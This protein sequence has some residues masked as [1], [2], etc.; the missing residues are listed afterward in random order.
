MK[1]YIEK[2]KLSLSYRQDETDLRK[3]QFELRSILSRKLIDDKE[4]FNQK[5]YTELTSKQLVGEFTNYKIT[6]K[7]IKNYNDF[8]ELFLNDYITFYLENLYNN[9][10]KDFVINDVSHK[11]ILLLLDLKFKKL[12]DEEE[13]LG[14][15]SK[16]SKDEEKDKITLQNVISKILWLEANS[17]YIKNILDL[18]NIIS[19]NI[20]YDENEKDFLFKQMLN[21]LS[22]I[23]IKYEP[24]GEPHLILVNIPFYK[25]II[26]IFKCIVDEQ[27]IKNVVS[28]NQN[29]N[30]YSY[31]KHLEY[32]FK[33]LE[34]LDQ[35]LRLNIIEL[36]VLK[37]FI[38]IYNVFELS[39]KIKKLDISLLINYLTKSLEI[40][41]KND[42][43]KINLLCD[44]LKKLI[45]IIKES[46]YDLSKKE[47][48][49]GDTIYYE[50]ISGVFLN[51]L[52][53]ENNLEYKIYILNEFLLDD[54]K[55]FIQ[56]NQILKIILE[57]FVSTDIY[58][59]QKSLFNLSD[60]KLKIL[61]ENTNNEWIKE[62]LIYTFE[63]ISLIYILNLIN[64]DENIN[65]ENNK[66]E[67]CVYYLK[68]FFERCIELLENLY[69]D[70]LKKEDDKE[71]NI[72]LQKFF[73]LAFIRVYLRIFIDWVNNNKLKNSET[74]EIIKIINGD[75]NN[76]F[77][78][79]VRYFIYKILYNMYAQDISK[80]FDD[81]IIEKFHLNSYN[82]FDLLKKERDKL[83]SFK[84][85]LFIEAYKIADEEYKIYDEQFNKLSYCLNNSGDKESELME[86][87]NNN[88]VDIFYSV[89]S[90][91]ISAYLSSSPDDDKK[92][93]LSNIIQ[94]AFDEKKQLLNIFKL[95]I[96][97][98][99]Y[100]KTNISLKSAEILQFSLRYCLNSDEISEDCDN[101]YY[102]LYCNDQNISSFIPGN[103]L[104]ESKIY[105]AYSKIKKYLYTH[106]SSHGVYICTCNI[107]KENEEIT[108]K[109]EEGN[110]GYPKESEKCQYCGEPIGKD[111]EQK[112]FYERNYYFRIF[113]DEKDLEEESKD[114]VKGNCMTLETFFNKFITPKL[115]EDSK[116]VNISRK[117]YFELNDKPI[118]NQ[119]Q[120]CFRLMNLILYSHLFTNVLSNGKD[121]LFAG[122]NLSYLDYIVGNW[123]K[124]KLLL[125]EKGINNMYIFINI[126]YKDLYTFLNE[127]KQINDY[128]KLL[129]VEKQIEKI[130][131]NKIFKKTQKIKQ[132]EYSKYEVY[133]IFYQKNKNK[134]K[135]KDSN[136]KTSIIK[137]ING[138]EFYK[139]EKEYPYYKNF[140]YSDSLNLNF[141]KQKLEERDKEKYPVIDLYLNKENLEK[142]I[143]KEFLDFNF[144]IKSLLNE[145]S[146]QIKK[147]DI[148]KL[149]FEK[150]NVYKIYKKRCETFV[151]II[152][153]KNKEKQL[154]EKSSLDNY[155]INGS[156]EKGKKLIEIYKEYAEIQNNL[157]ENIIKRINA[158][159]FDVLECQEINIQEAQNED[160]LTL[161][162]ENKSESNEIFLMNT[163]R[164]IYGNNSKVKYNNYN[165]YSIIFDKIEK[166]FEDTL[167]RNASFL[168]TDEILEM[169]YSAEDFL[170]DGI[171]ELNKNIKSESLNEK[172][173]MEFLIFYEK[174]LKTN[175]TSCFEVNEGLKNIIIYV[176]KNIKKINYSKSLFD[177][178]NEGAFS[179]GNTIKDC[180]K[181]FLK[182]N[183]NIKINK[184]TNLILFFEILY[185]E[186]AMEKSED[187]KDKIDDTIK[188]KISEYYKNKNGQL[189]T[190]ERLSNTIVK[191]LLNIEMNENNGKTGLIEMN[192]NLFDYLNNQ[193]LWSN[194]IYQDNRFTKECEEYKELNILVKNAYDFY[195]DIS[196]DGKA[197]FDKEKNAILD[198]IRIVEIEKIKK[199]KE[200]EREKEIKKIIEKE[201]E[202]VGE[203]QENN[204]IEDLDDADMDDL[205]AF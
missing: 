38:K 187:Y 171:N 71:S 30:Y 160:L 97:T 197:K 190:K 88:R 86:L 202:T 174:D 21:Y 183:A 96:D 124:L 80:L 146:G 111:G 142:K 85:I 200:K 46:L 39:G 110:N 165:S 61:E 105:S 11:I 185:F 158:V 25:I 163:F 62:T 51:E 176:N 2:E 10:I 22:K 83:S 8:I 1:E 112:S 14:I 189:L 100:N 175:L 23:E 186:L 28:K 194:D 162:F 169:K 136:N 198:K 53:R 167:I 205:D 103:D 161:E 104:K 120:I 31:F 16:E 36:S 115:E 45:K 178:I 93:I 107:D 172:D 9:I 54:I 188:G 20:V 79:M 182:N 204:V 113:K 140:L 199:E 26:I 43:N 127:Q 41:E 56:T 114:K 94:N 99:K 59:F 55:M 121:E 144:V 70:Q 179:Y 89:F 154:T 166:L 64:E 15:N 152:N 95:F 78:D 126:I 32:C 91:K 68:S 37:E 92:Q 90:T 108:L 164:E 77:R 76:P 143:N 33:E 87:I 82:N 123:N 6:D 128:N 29:D 148:N 119:S 106:P 19:E 180:L 135:E 195:C 125:Q 151:K 5:L 133:L 109:F 75:K 177:I 170:N 27:T 69:K 159:N 102:P 157:L 7:N 60:P 155:L 191:F 74:E 181:E 17:K 193:Y 72:N 138:V 81:N 156:N 66:K 173:K 3:C 168:K 139:E 129:E 40:I 65:N 141:F 13:K 84:D 118:R 57:D 153:S 47:T 42:E 131:E 116:G 147:E 101:I 73:A 58:L 130:I 150:S 67:C 203:S 134:Y 145:Y 63:Y 12:K 184:L 44:N 98:S 132:K 137:E 24:K 50:L 117:Q 34:K 35:T 201:N 52:K 149:T 196:F 49:K 122:E 48:I 192:D 18:Y 4:S